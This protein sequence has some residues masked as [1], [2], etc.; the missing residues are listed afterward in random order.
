M[1]A[2]LAML[3]L[4]G[5][6]FLILPHASAA[7]LF[8]VLSAVIYLCYGGGF[9]AM[10]ATAGDFFGLRHAGAVYGLMIV[11][12][13]AGGVIGPLLVA[14]LISGDDYTTAFTTVGVM[15]LA[16]M[17][18]PRVTRAPGRSAGTAAEPATAD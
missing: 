10:P 11:A 5:V 6:C 17:V 8:A 9:G 3:G 14:R 1:T 7:A 13:S 2:F 12:W 16:A 15:A 4:Q 18:L